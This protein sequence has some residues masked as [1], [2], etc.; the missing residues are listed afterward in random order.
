LV[1]VRSLNQH[2][3]QLS[4]TDAFGSKVHVR[5]FHQFTLGNNQLNDMCF[6][7]RLKASTQSQGRRLAVIEFRVEDE[8]G[9]LVASG[10][11]TVG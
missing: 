5:S 9:K 10:H 3:Y 6:D 1:L 4:P 8:Q 7:D 2:Y 11:H